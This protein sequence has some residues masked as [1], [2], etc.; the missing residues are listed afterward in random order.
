MD[1]KR[2]A[3]ELFVPRP[4]ALGGDPHVHA[5]ETT[6]SMNVVLEM[7]PLRFVQRLAGRVQ[8]DDRREFL[9][10]TVECRRIG[11]PGQTELVMPGHLLE[12]FLGDGD[13][14]A[15][16]LLR[17]RHHEDFELGLTARRPGEESGSSKQGEEQGFH[18]AEHPPASLRGQP[19]RAP[20]DSCKA[21][22]ASIQVRVLA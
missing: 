2:A 9:Q 6:A 19:N 5:Y 14:V 12:R 17:N 18:D 22:P 7:F 15:V 8:K 13:A 16:P 10:L 21:T 3:D 11:R 20:P 4:F 1:A